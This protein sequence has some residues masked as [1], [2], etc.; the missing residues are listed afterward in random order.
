MQTAIIIG[1]GPA[2]LTAAYELLETTDIHPIVIE[3]EA[4]VGGLA[5]TMHHNGCYIDVGGHRFFTKDKRIKEIW[6]DLLPLQ[7]EPAYDDRLLK[8][9]CALQAGG[10]DPE[11]TDDVLLS[12]T[13]LSRIL[14]DEHFFSYP[15]TLGA[16]TIEN[17]GPVRLLSILASYVAAC[18]HPKQE[19]SLEDFL[20]N[21]FGRKLY[22]LFFRDYTYKV[23]GRYPSEID[24]SWG[25]Q[26]IKGVSIRKALAHIFKKNSEKEKET[27][28]IDTFWYPKYGPGQLWEAMAKRIEEKGGIIIKNA[29]VI[30]LLGTKDHLTGVTIE[31]PGGERTLK[32][33]SLFSSMPIAEL[34]PALP[35]TMISKEAL[36]IAKALP[37]R[38]FIT[39]GILTDKIDLTNETDRPTLGDIPPDCWI[40]IQE[41]HIHMGRLQIFNNWSPYLVKDP[42][43]QVWLGLE[44]FVKEGDPLWQMDDEAFIEMAEDELETMGI[45]S[46]RHVK[47]AVRYRVKKAYPAYF[48][49]YED[50]PKVRHE[51]DKI[52][53]LYCIGR[54]GQH[55]YN[56]MD[57]SMLTAIEAVRNLK[58]HLPDKENVW[59]VNT[60]QDY[61]EAKEGE[62]KH[63]N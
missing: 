17:L 53:N 36:A 10:P 11:T 41:P 15:V 46:K 4:F 2:G 16:E 34:A 54:N 47:D 31:T 8:R 21:R 48:D 27:S 35:K 56:N 9:P 30:E 37:Y 43:H 63:G 25:A 52:T 39:V 49:A 19:Q 5:R 51:L 18:A 1:A 60:E 58:K 61:H 13:R 3:Q 33:D 32:A 26:R 55:R 29:K 44:Y 42:L 40:Y 23:W 6:Q 22:E 20:I 57:H 24:V 12:R 14:Y 62:T 45:L 38:D 59:N 7:G 28:F 50:F